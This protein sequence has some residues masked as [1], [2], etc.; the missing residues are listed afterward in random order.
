MT[1]KNFHQIA[2]VQDYEELFF[3]CGSFTS[4]FMTMQRLAKDYGMRKC[5]EYEDELY[6][7]NYSEYV[8][9]FMSLVIE[10]ANKLYGDVKSHVIDGNVI[11]DRTEFLKWSDDISLANNIK[12]KLW[13]DFEY[14]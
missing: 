1:T 6:K 7:K 12:N 14:M 5:R 11:C 13:K 2:T 10:E 4:L 3:E 9:A 8:V